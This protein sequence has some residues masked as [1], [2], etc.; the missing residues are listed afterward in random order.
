MRDKMRRRFVMLDRDGTLIYERHYL[1]DP[2]Q[3]ELLPG[4]IEGLRLLRSMGVGLVVLTN[5][6]GLA[7]GFFDQAALEKIHERMEKLLMDQ[8]LELDGIYYCPHLPEDG[9]ACRKPA[10][11]MVAR[12]A[13]DLDFDPA[14][15]FMVG[16]KDVDVQLGKNIG[17]KTILVL[18]GHGQR[19]IER[20][21]THP[22][23]IVATL[24][25]LPK[26]VSS[27]LG[28]FSSADEAIV[29]TPGPKN[30]TSHDS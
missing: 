15:G 13:Q 1:A 19:E 12:A 24:A 2:E 21:L 22:D 25:E 16:D 18:T 26:I 14:Q 10:V 11:G 17:A 20:G 7:R 8:G 30:V 27:Y 9:C 5:Q 29:A 3:V 23:H 28:G 4:V 6:S